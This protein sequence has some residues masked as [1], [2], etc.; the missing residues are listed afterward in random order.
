MCSWRP[1]EELLDAAVVARVRADVLDP[2]ARYFE[3]SDQPAGDHIE[4]AVQVQLHRALAAAPACETTTR[5]AELALQMRQRLFAGGVAEPGEPDDLDGR[6]KAWCGAHLPSHGTGAELRLWRF[7]GT[8]RGLACRTPLAAGEAALRVPEELLLTAAPTLA[9]WD[10][11]QHFRRSLP[12]A[13]RKRVPHLTK[14]S[15]GCPHQPPVLPPWSQTRASSLGS[16]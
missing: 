14:G 13:T 10:Q 5:N 11:A 16:P 2:P 8:G 7:E 1:N 12:R 15:H 3:D 9:R 6:L 4:R